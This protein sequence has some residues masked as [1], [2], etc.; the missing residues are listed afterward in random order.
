MTEKRNNSIVFESLRASIYTGKTGEVSAAVKKPRSR[1][2]F[3]DFLLLLCLLVAT[4]DET[5]EC[6]IM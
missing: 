6:K 1:D 3:I 2:G 5:L 4:S